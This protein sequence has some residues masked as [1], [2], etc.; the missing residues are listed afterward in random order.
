MAWANP[1]PAWGGTARVSGWFYAG[2][3]NSEP[4]LLSLDR[5]MARSIGV[6]RGLA[7]GWAWAGLVLEREHL[8]LPWLAAA[9]L[10]AATAFTVWVTAVLALDDRGVF[11]PMFIAGELAISVGLLLLDGLVYDALR[12]Q[13]LPWAWPAAAI[14]TAAV[15]G[16]ARWGL[17]ASTLIAGASFVGESVLRDAPQWT[18]PAASKSALFV[19]AAVTGG[20]A[21]ERLR[22]AEER[23]SLARSREELARVLHDGVLQ[24]LAVITRRSSDHDLRALA[25]EQERELRAYVSAQH[26]TPTPLTSALEHT[27]N[28]ATRRHGLTVELVIAEDLPPIDDASTCALAGAVGEALT[29]AAKHSGADQVVVFVEPDQGERGVMCA[30]RDNGAGF[31]PEAVEPGLGMRHSILDRIEAIGG[32]VRIDT[33]PGHGT[34]VNLWVT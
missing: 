29:N 3:V 24:T 7:L 28:A 9:A 15:V 11:T 4:E 10:A 23:I 30:V 26:H 6:F 32:R 1:E 27:V 5:G 16:G 25:A 22:D 2:V 12:Q 17:M 18:T 31:D 19:L 14:I 8:D 34:E 20:A 13:S 33:K 21:A